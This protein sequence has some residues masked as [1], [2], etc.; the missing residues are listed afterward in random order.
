MKVVKIKY[1]NEKNEGFFVKKIKG[2]VQVVIKQ[3]ETVELKGITE[4]EEVRI[5][6]VNLKLEGVSGNGSYFG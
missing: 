2:Y 3:G 5:N 4:I 1:N 6:E